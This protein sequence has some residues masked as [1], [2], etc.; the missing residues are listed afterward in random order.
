MGRL[1]EAHSCTLRRIARGRSETVGFGRFLANRKV[2]WSTILDAAGLDLSE[3][4][5]GQ[6]VLAIQ[7]TTEVNFQRHAGRV[8]GLGSVGNGKDLGL[9]VHPVIAISADSG[10]LLGLAGAQIW[11]R[12][13]P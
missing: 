1:V 3:R 11:T 8:K 9:F 6:H 12:L 2:T 10:A 4:V 5:A 13:G 7:D